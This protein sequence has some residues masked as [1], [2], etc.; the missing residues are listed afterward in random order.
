MQLLVSKANE[1]IKRIDASSMSKSVGKTL[2][3]GKL[4]LMEGC[5]FTVNSRRTQCSTDAT[6]HLNP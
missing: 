5:I 3:I 2:K 1:F 4:L 6:D